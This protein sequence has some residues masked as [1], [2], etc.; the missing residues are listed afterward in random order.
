MRLIKE[1]KVYQVITT[2]IIWIIIMEIRIFGIM[3][4]NYYIHIN[5]GLNYSVIK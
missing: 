1:K 5:G 4:M 2:I 3:E